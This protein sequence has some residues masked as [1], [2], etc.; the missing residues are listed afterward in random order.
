MMI[1]KLAYASPW[2][3][4]SVSL[5]TS[6]AVGSLVIC[7]AVRSF[8]VS[9]VVLTIMSCLAVKY[10]RATLRRYGGMMLWPF[11]F[12]VLGT[13]AIL[14]DLADEPMGIWNVPIGGKYLVITTYSLLYS[15]RLIVVSLAS[16]SCLYFLVLTTPVLDLMGL[17]RRLHCPWLVIELMMLIYRFIFVL[18]DSALS[19]TRAQNCRLGNR[20]MRTSITSMG[21]MLAAL[22]V[23]AVGKASVLFDTMEARCYDGRIRVLSENVPAAKRE[24]ILVFAYLVLLLLMAVFC[25]RM[26]GM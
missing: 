2:R 15:L 21:N 1:D 26:G 4:K 18:L 24:K 9:G 13:I 19:I 3:Y 5:K 6:L 14:L 11:T 22:L 12:L 10:S 17:L 20:D 8:L 16:V 23:Q 7:V 25:S